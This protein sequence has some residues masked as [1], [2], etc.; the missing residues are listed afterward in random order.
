MNVSFKLG[1]VINGFKV[2]NTNG[3]TEYTVENDDICLRFRTDA[4]SGKNYC[5]VLSYHDKKKNRT[6]RAQRFL[7]K[8]VPTAQNLSNILY[9]RF[10][11]ENGNE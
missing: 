9:T 6:Y 8:Y 4:G 7:I 1:E 2:I 5:Q 3:L 11:K 10:R